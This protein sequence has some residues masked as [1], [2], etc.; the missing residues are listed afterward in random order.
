M[1]SIFVLVILRFES[2]QFVNVIS[3]ILC[4]VLTVYCHLHVKYFLRPKL[5]VILA[6]LDS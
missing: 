2:N 1:F 6:F 5:L 3:K 4:Q